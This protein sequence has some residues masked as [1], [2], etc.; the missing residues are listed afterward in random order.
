MAPASAASRVIYI[1]L[2]RRRKTTP[3][4]QLLTTGSDTTKTPRS[5]GLLRLNRGRWRIGDRAAGAMPIR[6]VRARRRGQAWFS[7]AVGWTRGAVGAHL[8]LGVRVYT[9]QITVDGKTLTGIDQNDRNQ[10]DLSATCVAA[11]TR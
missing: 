4:T 11:P 8:N 6:G 9:V 10:I 7:L 3:T 2:G 5:R 1:K